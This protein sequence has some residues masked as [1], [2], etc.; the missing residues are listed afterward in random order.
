[1]NRT[2]CT[3]PEVLRHA[4][5]DGINRY[6]RE[7]LLP[8]GA[9]TEEARDQADE[10]FKHHLDRLISETAAKWQTSDME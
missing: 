2:I 9:L 10:R 1:M 4:I 6:V 5:R 7:V 3:D 8:S